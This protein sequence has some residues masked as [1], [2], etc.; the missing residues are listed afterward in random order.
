MPP[1]GLRLGVPPN[2]FDHALRLMQYSDTVFEARVIGS[3]KNVAC[4]S[5][6]VYPAEPLQE[7][8]I[9]NNDFTRL[10]PNRVPNRIVDNFCPWFSPP[11]QPLGV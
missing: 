4:Q 8:R 6:L 2:R 3:G 9:N 1:Q 7:R 10:N 5:K 11:P